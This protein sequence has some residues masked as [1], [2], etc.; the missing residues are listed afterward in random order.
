MSSPALDAAM[1]TPV[2]PRKPPPTNAED[3][4][5]I[6]KVRRYRVRLRKWIVYSYKQIKQNFSQNPPA[7][8]ADPKNLK[9]S[10]AGKKRDQSTSGNGNADK[11]YHSTSDASTSSGRGGYG[12]D[13]G[14]NRSRGSDR[15][16]R[17]N[18]RG[19]V[20]I[21]SKPNVSNQTATAGE[22]E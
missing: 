22:C 17:G 20:S 14:R 21:M 1:L 13:R 5:K 12:G 15:G 2:Q 10:D 4:F 19:R 18:Y 9:D 3:N 8:T 16:K 11:R 7:E 6:P